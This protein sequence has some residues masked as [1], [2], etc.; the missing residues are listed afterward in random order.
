MRIQSYY[1]RILEY[2]ND[3]SIELTEKELQTKIILDEMLELKMDNLAITDRA[4]FK[5][6]NAKHK[7]YYA[8]FLIHA[9]FIERVIAV[10]KATF[11]QSTFDNQ[12]AFIRYLITEKCKEAIT[13]AMEKGESYNIAYAANI[14]GKHHCTDQEDK[15]KPPFEQIIPFLPIPTMDVSVLGLKP[16]E[17]IKSV[18]A[19]LRKKYDIKENEEIIIKSKNDTESEGNIF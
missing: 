2:Y 19:K 16:I 10:S 1:D 12:K 13:I 3:N 15:E 5:E 17:N 6:I 4:W 18:V 14:M 7:L 11:S 8:Q 9:S